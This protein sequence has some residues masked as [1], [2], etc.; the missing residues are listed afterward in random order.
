MEKYCSFLPEIR[1]KTRISAI[2][3]SHFSQL[4]TGSLSQYSK[5]RK[6]KDIG[7]KKKKQN[8]FHPDDMIAYVES[9]RICRQTITNN[10]NLARLQDIRSIYKNICCI[11]YT[12]NKKLGNTK[13]K[14]ILCIFIIYYRYVFIIEKNQISRKENLAKN[15]E[16]ST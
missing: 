14:I 2:T 11:S 7:L 12:R 8:Y 16:E 3:T 13:F 9:K 1:N 15:V 4:Y 6:K 10:V 5:A